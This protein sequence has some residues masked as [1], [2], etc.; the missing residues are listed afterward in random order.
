MGGSFAGDLP[1]RELERLEC[2]SEARGDIGDLG[3]LGFGFGLSALARALEA[4]GVPF[5]AGI[6]RSMED[7]EVATR[8]VP[9]G[10]L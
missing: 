7:Q 8:C 9:P 2:V 1:R 6:L 5:A 3:V 10:S 4:P